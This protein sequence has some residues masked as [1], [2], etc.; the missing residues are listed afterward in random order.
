MAPILSIPYQ[1]NPTKH[2]VPT[3]I[4]SLAEDS[5][6]TS[7]KPTTNKHPAYEYLSQQKA[8]KPRRWYNEKKSRRISVVPRANERP[9]Y[10]ALVANEP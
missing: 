8:A 7:L 9:A 4:K 10:Q 6:N 3:A 2:I 1:L 5:R